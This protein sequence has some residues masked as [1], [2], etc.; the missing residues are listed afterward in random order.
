MPVQRRRNMSKGGGRGLFR[1]LS[2]NAVRLLDI[3]FVFQKS[4]TV[5]LWGFTPAVILWGLTTEPRPNPIDL[6][7]IW[8]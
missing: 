7:N 6:I 2:K 5:L 3:D 4:R 1:T 8:E